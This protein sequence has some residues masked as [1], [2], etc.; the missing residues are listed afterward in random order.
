M[1]DLVTVAETVEEALAA[2]G[3]YRAGGTDV[4][5]R[6]RRGL[7]RGPL[8]DIHRLR[9]HDTVS[10]DETGATI[11]A[12]V[13]LHTLATD[14]ALAQDYPGL[15]LAAGSLATPQI[16]N[17]ATLGGSLLQRTRCW[18]YRHPQIACYKSGADRCPAR[19]GQNP[20]GVV[21]DLGPCVYPHP[22]TMGMALLAYEAAYTT[23][24]KEPRP[25]ATLFGDG[26]DPYHDNTLE[27]GEL[28]TS[29]HLPP[30][31][32]H[33]QAAYFRAIARAEAEWPLVE[34]LARLIVDAGTITLARVAVGGV[35]NIP[36]RL[37]AVEAALEE[38][39]ATAATVAQAAGHAAENATP[40]PQTRYKVH[41]LVNTVLETMER[42]LRT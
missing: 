13:H 18:Y 16:R 33:E 30:P 6:R 20:N 21:F 17:M 32:A 23:Y 39:P 9:D 28:L 25:L 2:T 34:C 42:A 24:G 4:Q 7:S 1:S 11:G 5:A 36:L 14:E 41:F 27:A 10:R 40:L 12:L 29:I 8:V 38:Q 31:A 19:D 35:A 3:E 26:T 37:P 22:S 15:A